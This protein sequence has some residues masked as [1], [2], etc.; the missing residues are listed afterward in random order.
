MPNAGRT[1]TSG[2][3]FWIQNTGLFPYRPIPTP[4]DIAY[5]GCADAVVLTEP[6]RR[7]SIRVEAPK[8]QSLTVQ[9]ANLVNIL[10][11]QARVDVH[12][13]A[14]ALRGELARSATF[15]YHVTAVVTSGSEKQ[16]A[17]IDAAA[18]VARVADKHASG[19]LAM[20]EDPCQPVR[21]KSRAPGCFVSLQDTVALRHDRALPLPTHIIEQAVWNVLL[22]PLAQ[23][24][25]CIVCHCCNLHLLYSIITRKGTCSNA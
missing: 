4:N 23:G 12:L 6:H 16:V 17:R 19:Y 25:L 10:L 9:V 22:K 5:G 8:M 14:D 13:A 21:S 2:N 24:R 7:P 20:C 3:N 1:T 18:I 11:S 15:A